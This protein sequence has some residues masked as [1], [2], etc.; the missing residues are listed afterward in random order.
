MLF[1]FIVMRYPES[2]WRQVGLKALVVFR[3]GALRKSGSDAELQTI[4]FY[5]S[6]RHHHHRR[7][8]RLRSSDG[9]ACGGA[10]PGRA[11]SND[12]AEELPPWLASWLSPWLSKISNLV[13]LEPREA[14]LQDL[15][16]LLL[17][18]SPTSSY[19][20]VT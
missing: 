5:L 6:H 14:Y 10:T 16:S 11:R 18:A 13:G 17:L 8:H 4:H 19:P 3:K 15:R 2:I 1:I 20:K 9:V 7:R 12:L